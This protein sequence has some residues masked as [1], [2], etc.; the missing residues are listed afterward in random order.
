M[1]RCKD[2]LKRNARLALVHTIF[3]DKNKDNNNEWIVKPAVWS[4]QWKKKRDGF[5]H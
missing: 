4:T 3:S 2:F 1:N 5:E